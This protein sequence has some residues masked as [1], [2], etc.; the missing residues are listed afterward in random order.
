MT[1]R[2]DAVSQVSKCLKRD[3]F[4][5]AIAVSGSGSSDE[6]KREAFD[7]GRVIGIIGK[8]LLT[9]GLM[10]IMFHVTE[11]FVSVAA[12]TAVGIIPGS[13]Q[14][15]RK[16][17]EVKHLLPK[18]KQIMTALPGYDHAGPSSRNHVLIY[19]ANKVVLMPGDAGSIAE[20]KLAVGVYKKPAIAFDP[21]LR[22]TSPFLKW[23]QC[24]RE[25]SVKRVSSIKAVEK[26]LA[27]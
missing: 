11:G 24:V 3:P 8:D 13:E 4:E 14:A 6:Y 26:W 25:L 15:I 18:V 27:H 19:L 16:A 23:Q 22:R 10:G 20:A 7:L 2:D 12:G 1:A 5:H 9:G 21:S 17:K